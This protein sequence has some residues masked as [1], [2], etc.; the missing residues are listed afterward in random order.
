MALLFALDGVELK[1]NALD[2]VKAFYTERCVDTKVLNTMELLPDQEPWLMGSLRCFDDSAK[3]EES[4]RDPRA[5]SR[6]LI[7]GFDDNGLSQR[8]CQ[9]RLLPYLVGPVLVWS[10]FT[11]E[12]GEHAEAKDSSLTLL[13]IDDIIIMINTRMKEDHEKAMRL[14]RM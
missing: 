10:Q 7:F 11:K 6:S 1:E 3:N 8:L 13:D 4:F 5:W 9:N 14:I 12:A 2:A